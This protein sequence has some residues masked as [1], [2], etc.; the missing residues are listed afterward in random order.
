LAVR[1]PVKS[2]M[3]RKGKR[4]KLPRRLSRR[5]PQLA[6]G[7]LQCSHA[8]LRSQIARKPHSSSSG[9]TDCA[10]GY[11]LRGRCLLVYAQPPHSAF[12]RPAC[13][14]LL[15]CLC[16]SCTV[17]FSRP[18][19]SLSLSLSHPLSH[20]PPS[21]L[22]ALQ[23]QTP[24][25]KRSKQRSRHYK[26]TNQWLSNSRCSKKKFLDIRIAYPLYP[27]QSD[28]NLTS[29]PQPFTLSKSPS[30]WVDVLG[31]DASDITYPTCAPA[32]ILG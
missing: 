20:L 6:A 4:A 13:A 28:P 17:P 16:T 29:R 12:V 7:H 27:H 9:R 14:L 2:R 22:P 18:L 19:S 26:T 32:L 1:G 8:Q 24:K 15:K 3:L 23:T 21:P 5:H 11:W 31:G 25:A 10:T 30:L